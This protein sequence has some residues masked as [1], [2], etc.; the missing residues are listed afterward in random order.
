MASTAAIEFLPFVLQ[1]GR[2]IPKIEP[3]LVSK[4]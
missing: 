1:Y 4:V 3:T 2:D